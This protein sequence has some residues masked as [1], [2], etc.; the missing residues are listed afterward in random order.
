MNTN[1]KIESSDDQVPEYVIRAHARSLKH[2]E[3]A[4]ARFLAAWKRAVSMIGSPYFHCDGVDHY[5]NATNRE[6][7]RPNTEMIDRHIGVCSTGQGVFI[8]AVCSFYNGSWGLNLSSIHGYSAHGDIA[9]RLDL[10]QN[11]I[12]VELMLNHTGW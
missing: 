6:Q 9:G 11:E 10:Q 1:H 12:L 2:Y 8:G 7:I 5:T 3:Q 4:P